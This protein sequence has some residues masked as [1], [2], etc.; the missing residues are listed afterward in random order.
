MLSRRD[1]YDDLHRHAVE[2]LIPVHPGWVTGRIENRR[3]MRTMDG[4]SRAWRIAADPI[5]AVALS[6]PPIGRRGCKRDHSASA[7]G[8]RLGSVRTWG[9]KHRNFFRWTTKSRT[10]SAVPGRWLELLAIAA[11]RAPD[12]VRHVMYTMAKVDGTGKDGAEW[13]CH[14]EA[15]GGWRGKGAWVDP[16]GLRKGSSGT[17]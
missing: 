6:A 13:R 8:W 10:L 11:R 17:S 9:A 2:A 3:S 12:G 7:G 14:G 5:G 1:Q 4:M 16:S 15:G